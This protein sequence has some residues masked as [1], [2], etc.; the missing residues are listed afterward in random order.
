[1]IEALYLRSLDGAISE[2]AG[3]AHAQIVSGL[4]RS[5]FTQALWNTRQRFAYTAVFREFI[6]ERIREQVSDD[7]WSAVPPEDVLASLTRRA[8]TP[9]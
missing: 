2:Q 1:M 5:P 6:G 8:S 7:Y 3:E 9:A 4:V